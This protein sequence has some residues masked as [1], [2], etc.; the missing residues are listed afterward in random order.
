MA[1]PREFDP[2]DVLS[3]AQDV[4][5]S[6]GYRAT[7]LDDVTEATGVNK[8]SLYA[9]F[10]G[11]REL[12]CAVLDRY[13]AMLLG[14]ADLLLAAPSTREALSAWLRSFLPLCTGSVG[15]R[16]CLSIN[17]IVSD[18]LEEPGVA[19]RISAYTAALEQKL[20]AACERGMASGEL[21]CTFDPQATVQLL[22]ALRTG[23]MVHGRLGHDARNAERAV[24]RTLAV[25][26]L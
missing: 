12:F 24:D 23:L 8:P 15:E 20:L 14:Y 3:R 10:G 9:A 11:K 17:T 13:H 4:F 16:G 7:S 5:W 26:G 22:L 25:L 18:A 21:P 1:R 6:R 2:E 19:S